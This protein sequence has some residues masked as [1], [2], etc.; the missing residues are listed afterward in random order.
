MDFLHNDICDIWLNSKLMKFV[1]VR[2]DGE[3]ST[4]EEKPDPERGELKE[5]L[6]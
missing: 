4:V 3:I 2:A 5:R 6:S 1:L